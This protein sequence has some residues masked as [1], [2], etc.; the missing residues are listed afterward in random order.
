MRAVTSR[1]TW[2]AAC[3]AGLLVLLAGEAQARNEQLRWQHPNPSTVAGFRVKVGS[4]S[5]SYQTTIDVGLPAPSGGVYSYNLTVP[6]ANSVYVV[7][8]AYGPTGLESTPSNEQLRRGLL[9]AP[10][11]PTLAP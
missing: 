7:V 3:A 6:D 1:R 10:G 5:G 9:G 4:S 11:K 8:T 2:R